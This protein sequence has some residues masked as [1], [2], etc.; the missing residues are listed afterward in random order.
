MDEESTGGAVRQR[1]MDSH[2]ELEIP[3]LG[4]MLRLIGRAARLRCPNCGSGPVLRHWLEIRDRCGHC[5]IRL[6]RGEH[7]YFA[8]SILLNYCLAGVIA[9][10]AL[11]VLLIASW[12]TVPWN[13]IRWV[14]PLTIVALPFLLFPFSK[15]LWLA[16]D[17]AIRP[18]TDAELEWHRSATREFSTDERLPR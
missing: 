12:P 15:L 16:A 1:E 18:V 9:I 6:E 2:A 4:R 13:T 8:G 10:V 14:A 17:I 3:T 7:D 5:G 11:L